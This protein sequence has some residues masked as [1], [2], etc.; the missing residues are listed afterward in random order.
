[1]KKTI[2]V[3][4]LALQTA[5]VIF[6]ISSFSLNGDSGPLMNCSIICALTLPLVCLAML[7]AKVAVC[8]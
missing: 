1:M 2:P 8:L 4:L 6:S 5:S 7:T 3:M